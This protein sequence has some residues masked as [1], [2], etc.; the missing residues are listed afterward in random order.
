[1]PVKITMPRLSDTMEEGTLIKWHV[2]VGDAVASGDH[3][4]DVETDKATMELQAFDDGTVA[5]LPVGEGD[6]VPVGELILL[7]AEEGESAEEA[8]KN[9]GDAKTDPPAAAAPEDGVKKDEPRPGDGESE[10]TAGDSGDADDAKPQAAGGG[11]FGG[12]GASGGGGGKVRI[13]PLAR[14]LA[15]E[16]GLDPADIEGTGPDGR[17]IKRD[18]LAAAKGGGGTGGQGGLG[19]NQADAKPQAASRGGKSAPPVAA[20]PVEALE[21]SLESRTITLSGMRKTIAKRLVESKT[22]VP[23]FQVSVAVDMDPLMELRGTINAQLESQGIK[24]S[25]NDFVTRAVALACAEHPAV[26][27]SW[28]VDKI[29][30]HGS[31]N[32]GVAISLP[33]EKGGGLLVATI[34]KAHAK[35]LRQIS[36]D[37]KQLA[38]NARSDKGLTVE[39]MSDS[40]ITISNL[41]MPQYGVT[42]FTAIINPPNAAIIAVGAAIEKPVVRDGHIVIGHEMNVTLSGDHRVIDG[43]VGAEYLA[44]MKRLLENPAAL[45]V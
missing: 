2:G 37:V 29:Q 14:K 12:G 41:G 5:Q 1:M 13:S 42:Q 9:A 44:T 21:G 35:G 28:D 31:V 27:S 32:V 10:T 33:P 18:V 45:L 19:Q 39:E 17:I 4:A 20:A 23:H 16:H 6:V 7:L 34:R 24:L 8:V 43:A 25:V 22:T 38:K 30:Q 11:A 3:L 36:R 26:N 15:D 40:T